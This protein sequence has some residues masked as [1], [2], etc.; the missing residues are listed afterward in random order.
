MILLSFGRYKTASFAV[1]Y[2]RA[3]SPVSALAKKALFEPAL[4]LLRYKRHLGLLLAA[5]TI[6]LRQRRFSWFQ[7]Y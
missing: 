1:E 5:H 2:I 6:C 3:M 4:Y 7:P